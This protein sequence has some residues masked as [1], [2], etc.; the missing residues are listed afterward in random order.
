MRTLYTVLY[1]I[2]LPFV[3]LR[4]WWRGRSNPGYRERWAE[5]L[6]RYAQPALHTD[7]IWVHAVSLGET[8]AAVPLI[9]KL[10]AQDPECVIVVTNTTP[11]GSAA[12]VKQFAEQRDRVL[13]V[14]LPFDLPFCLRRF[15]RC[16]HPRIG[17]LMETE[18]W[19]NT[20]AVAAEQAVPMVL[21][22]ARLSEKSY[23]CYARIAGVMKE[24]LGHLTF[25]AAQTEADASRFQALGM[26]ESKLGVTGSI[27]FDMQLPEQ[28]EQKGQA[29]RQGWGEQ[30][31]VFVA[32]STHEGEE[33]IV[34]EALTLLQQQYPQIL[35]ILVPRHP[36]R[37]DRVAKLC[38]EQGFRYAR[39]SQNEAVK[40]DMAVLLGDT[41]G[42][43]MLFY[44]ASDVA[45]VGGSLIE[46][47]GH[48]MLEPAALARPALTGP[49]VFNFTVITEM[50]L[51]A[52]AASE[53]TDAKTLAEQIGYLLSHPDEMRAM[54]ERGQAVMAKNRG[55]LDRAVAVIN[56]HMVL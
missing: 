34:L 15:F 30:R 49:H 39:R 38:E 3:F 56:D 5:R 45:F 47:G 54:G 8:I 22:N 23:R 46:R 55:A 40:E 29:L 37:F 31:P 2:M 16:F 44:A 33:A 9:K 25:I 53:V 36:E 1:F 42:E 52:K 35:L 27:K 7:P 11:T 26:P 18:L 19:P 41:M 20:L 24:M 14:Y 17:I 13:N 28:I 32:A 21:L 48:N 12:V 50:L 4:M 6:G 51:A 10:L 43:M